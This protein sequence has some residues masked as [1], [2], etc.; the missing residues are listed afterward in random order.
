MFSVVDQDSAKNVEEKWVPEIRKYLPKVPIVLIGT[1]TDLRKDKETLKKLGDKKPITFEEGKCLAKKIE[2][3][4]Y[5]EC[6]AIK[7]LGTTR[8]FV[9]AAKL[10]LCK[11]ADIPTCCIL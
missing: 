9:F 5:F 7:N 1:K 6:C 11:R 2:A 3:V 4:A 10:A 8:P